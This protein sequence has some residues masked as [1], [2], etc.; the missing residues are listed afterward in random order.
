MRWAVIADDLTGALDTALQ[1]QQ[2]GWRALVS[3]RP[4][5]WPDE[6]EVRALSTESRHLP[7][8]AAA[9][10]VLAAAHDL[11]GGPALRVYKKTDSLLRGNV[12]AE[13]RAVRQA[14]GQAPLVF[15]PAFP[16]GGRTTV[17]G[18]QRL[19]GAPVAQALP[20]RDPRAPVTESRVPTLLQSSTDLSVASVPL[21]VVRRGAPAVAAALH[22]AKRAG[23]GVV[24]P[25]AAS[26]D[27][28]HA[29]ALA[30]DLAGLGGVSAGSA[31]LAARLAF[32]SRGAGAHAA[33]TGAACAAAVIGTP[34]PHTQAQAARAVDAGARLVRVR[35]VG[36]VRAVVRQAQ[37]AWDAGRDVVF[38]AV[39]QSGAPGEP[40]RRAQM[41]RISALSRALLS[42]APGVGLALSGG[43]TA[44][45]ALEG[46]DVQ[47]IEI[48]GE[49]TW[50]VPIGLAK[51]GPLPIASIVTK[52]G[53]M[54][55]PE[56]LIEAF[57][58]LKRGDP[59][60]Q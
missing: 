21:A 31:G 26:D 14:L 25:D 1:F 50:G 32:Q 7:A 4:G 6:G 2:A 18:V 43:D 48:T 46:M 22:E 33:R 23:C 36:S 60:A 39:I 55:G 29:V 49:V 34:S 13:L 10:C 44:R 8:A 42:G 9:A 35:T 41:R 52:G 45:A 58:R 56:A 19:H 5:V 37:R 3:T 12:G 57:A 15:A 38:D 51:R 16:A 17:D 30:V 24:V 47:S 28:L 53:A 27:D 11:R 40:R 54:G 20:G 59:Q